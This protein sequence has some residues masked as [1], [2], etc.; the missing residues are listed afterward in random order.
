VAPWLTG[1]VTTTT[2]LELAKGQTV[3]HNGWTARVRYARRLSDQVTEVG[4]WPPN[5]WTGDCRK[6]LVAR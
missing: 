1:A 4:Y 6:W 5:P 3:T 2:L